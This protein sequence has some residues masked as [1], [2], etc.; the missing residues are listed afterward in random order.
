ML[1]AAVIGENQPR[2]DPPELLLTVGVDSPPDA[3]GGRESSGSGDARYTAMTIGSQI[4]G[5]DEESVGLEELFT[6]HF[7]RSDIFSSD[8]TGQRSSCS[9]SRTTSSSVLTT[10]SHSILEVVSMP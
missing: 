2:R 3:A 8:S 10:K 7:A 9:C 6:R 4:G 5:G 1:G